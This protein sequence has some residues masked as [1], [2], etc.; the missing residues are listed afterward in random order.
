MEAKWKKSFVRSA[1]LM[2]RACIKRGKE[3]PLLAVFSRIPA[4]ASIADAILLRRVPRGNDILLRS[5]EQTAVIACL[6]SL[7]SSS[8]R[9]LEILHWRKV[10]KNR[11]QNR[12]TCPKFKVA[13]IS[14]LHIYLLSCTLTAQV[15]VL[16]T[17]TFLRTST[18]LSLFSPSIAPQ[19]FPESLSCMGSMRAPLIGWEGIPKIP[20]PPPRRQQSPPPPPPN[21]PL[22]CPHL[23]L[24]IS[25]D[26]I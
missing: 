17:H 6:F 16:L 20:P 11:L 7:L 8:P 3:A 13:F 24:I 14:S 19:V 15:N 1:F 9:Q 26:L 25:V 10:V 23:I 21:L 22:N 2:R 5:W 12:Q 4:D 18:I